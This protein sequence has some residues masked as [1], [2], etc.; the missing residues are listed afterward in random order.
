MIWKAPKMWD[1][2]TCFIIGGGPSLVEQFQIPP[3]IV[4]EVRRNKANIST[5]SPYLEALHDKHVIG[6]NN[7]YLLGDWVDCCFFGDC[8]WYLVHRVPLAKF[9]GIKVT[10]CDRFANKPVA[11]CEGIKYLAKGG[12]KGLPGA[13]SKLYGISENPSKVAWNSNSGAA[14]ISLAAHF[15]VKRIILLGFDMQAP[16]G[17]T[18]WHFGH[19][20]KNKQ[21]FNRHLRGFPVIAKDAQCMGIE[22]F[23]ASPNS[24]IELFPK[25]TLEEAL[26]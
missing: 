26:K 18:H 19:N 6:V 2:G 22:I 23:N 15:G 11:K 8:A 9:Q 17:M 7:A 1:G 24:K 14:A 3:E 12:G 20:P 4:A 10:C 21:P 5:Y 16:D 13:D 25:L